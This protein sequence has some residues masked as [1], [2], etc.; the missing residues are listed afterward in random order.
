MVVVEFILEYGK[1]VLFC[2]N[3]AVFVF[4]IWST[5]KSVS[6]T[7]S[8]SVNDVL[9][10]TAHPDDEVM[11]FAPLLRS[12]RGQNRS[13]TVLCLSRGNTER[14]KEFLRSCAD[15][16]VQGNLDS[17]ED[18]FQ[19]CWDPEKVANAIVKCASKMRLR[20]LVTFD[21]FGVSGHP[22]HIACWRGAVQWAQGKK[23]VS[24]LFL[25]SVSLWRKYLG[26]FEAIATIVMGGASP[27][28]LSWD[29]FLVW[30]L[31]KNY[32]TQNVWYRKL[33]GLFSRYVYINTLVKNK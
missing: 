16:G 15:L 18:G 32:P 3:V 23:E 22:N 9:L 10:L 30:K 4:L 1:I 26:L 24:V 12:L 17:F 6:S 19:H 5:R 20:T 25:H 11:F 8:S 21:Q 2:V 7:S 13:V 14:E 31:M 33:Y 29:P 27:F 28:F